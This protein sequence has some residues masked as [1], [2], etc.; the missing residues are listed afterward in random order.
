MRPKLTEKQWQAQ[1]VQIAQL[2]GWHTYH[3]WLSIRSQPGFPDLVLVRER[4]IF[5]E[6]KAEKGKL[7]AHQKGWL[8]TLTTAGAE[9]YVWRPSDWDNVLRTLNRHRR[10]NR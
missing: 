8:D 10:E 6:L 4:V 7:T 3:T 1:V 5:A 9:V 2:A